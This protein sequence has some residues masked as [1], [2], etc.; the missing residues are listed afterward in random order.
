MHSQYCFC[1]SQAAGIARLKKLLAAQLYGAYNMDEVPP[2]SQE[3]PSDQ[4]DSQSV[5]AE[6]SPE[7][8]SNEPVLSDMPIPEPA[9]PHSIAVQ[10]EVEVLLPADP[11]RK[12]VFVVKVSIT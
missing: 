2:D 5:P 6:S 1:L 7:Q 11:S 12:K 4:V 8:P 10:G 9:I 3:I